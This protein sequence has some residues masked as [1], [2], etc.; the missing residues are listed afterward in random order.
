[1]KEKNKHKNKEPKRGLNIIERMGLGTEKE[2]FLES[3]SM[4][5][6]SGMNIVAA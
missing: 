2:Y 4:M 5:M 1:M 6:A 3:I